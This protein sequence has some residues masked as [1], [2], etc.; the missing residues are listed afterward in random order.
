MGFA[1]LVR[2]AGIE[3]DAFGGGGFACVN[4]GHDA[5]IALFVYGY[6]AGH[7]IS[8]LKKLLDA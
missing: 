4:M 7:G 6:G 1:E 3:K 5:D 8:S 2:H